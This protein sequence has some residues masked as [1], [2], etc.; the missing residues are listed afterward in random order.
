MSSW[1]WNV[2]VDCYPCADEDH[3]EA[4]PDNPSG[5]TAAV[6]VDAFPSCGIEGGRVVGGGSGEAGGN[7]PREGV[8]EEHG[9]MRKGARN[10]RSL[11]MKDMR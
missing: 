8:E 2:G 7:G 1:N 11:C 6:D 9:R 3:G 5:S 4:T 10:L